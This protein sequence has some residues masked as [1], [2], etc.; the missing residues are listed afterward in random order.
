MGSHI[1]QTFALLYLS[2]LQL[3]EVLVDLCLEHTT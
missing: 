1:L 2:P 3:G